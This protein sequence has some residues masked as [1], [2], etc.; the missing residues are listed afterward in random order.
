MNQIFRHFIAM[1][2]LVAVVLAGC[3]GESIID[4]VFPNTAETEI[5]LQTAEPETDE[6]TSRL[7]QTPFPVRDLVVWV[8][9]QFDPS[10]DQPG[11]QLLNQRLLDYQRDNPQF[12]IIVR[13]KAA[14]G[15]GGLLE[16]LTGA[17]AVAPESLPSLVLLN[18]AEMTQAI[19]KNLLA[20][21]D[22]LSAVIDEDD[23]YGFAQDM[24][25][26]Q[27]TTYGLPFVSNLL[28]IIYRQP[29]L[30][31]DQPDWDEVMRRFNQLAFSAGD[32]EALITLSLYLSTGGE[33]R[34]AQGH[35]M[36]DLD[37]LTEV[38]S[39]YAEGSRRGVFSS[40][41][42]DLQNDD[43]AWELFRD[44]ES[45][46]VITW[47]NRV[48]D[49][50]NSYQLAMLPSIG[51]L[52]YTTAS[53]WLWCLPA[54]DEADRQAGAELAEYLV[55]AEFLAEW[56]AE[57]GFFPVR[58]SSLSGWSES[59][60]KITIS[61]MLQSALLRPTRQLTSVISPELKNSVAEVLTR[62]NTPAESAQKL[63]ERLEVIDAQ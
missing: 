43:Q 20:P 41:L 15:P 30:E 56:S 32:P 35:Q 14:S 46:A 47:A 55:E 9:P 2:V 1:M 51:D 61:R 38:L 24:A 10:A 4:A 33:I 45:E 53:G 22:E 44:G 40:A 29:A 57:S 13:V 28:G 8:P 11:A 37:E 34:D 5:P 23:W 16:T 42:V 25:I 6:E 58:P 21:M 19:S 60:L 62:Q 39:M 63:I 17:S 7:T 18:R 52:P 26:Q 54:V 31:S 12:N 27:G 36:V 59:P 3:Q 49:R 48:F 50:Y